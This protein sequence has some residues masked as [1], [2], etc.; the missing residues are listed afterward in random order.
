MEKGLKKVFF[1]YIIL[2]LNINLFFVD[3]T[4]DFLGYIL[5]ANGLKELSFKNE[6]F[7]NGIIIARFLATY[8]FYTLSLKF[9]GLLNV[10]NIYLD[11]LLN[12]ALSILGLLLLDSILG[13]IFLEA[14]DKKNMQIE[15][16]SYNLLKC[17]IVYTFI[18]LIYSAFSLNYNHV[19]FIKIISS[20]LILFS[21]ILYIYMILF[22]R[23]AGKKLDVA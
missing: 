11:S 19:D 15:K 22:F 3:L 17:N 9:I 7:K 18:F 12:I 21:F 16:E 2:V 5:I 1:G 23:K 8:E 4:A 13:G 14:K 6:K 20:L 10:E